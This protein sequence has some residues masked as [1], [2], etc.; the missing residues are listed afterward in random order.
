MFKF[1]PIVK[2]LV[3]GTETWLLSSVRGFESI[4]AD[5]PSKGKTLNEVYGGEFP[6]LV[7][8]IDANDDLSIQVHPNDDLARKRHNCNGKTE[9]WYVR[10]SESRAQLLSGLCRSLSKEE[11]SKLVEDG[12]I[13]GALSRYEVK[14]GDVFFLPAGR[15]HSI[16]GGCHI[17]EIQ[18]TSDITYRI[19]DYNRPG[20]DGKPREL[21]TELAKDAIDFSVQEDYRT[22]YHPEKNEE[23]DIV[24]CNHFISSVF[25]LDKAVSKDVSGISDS[26]VILC[27]EGSG[28]INGED[29]KEGDL[30]LAKGENNIKFIP[31]EDGLKLLTSYVPKG[32]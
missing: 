28:K 7:K 23:I 26:Y 32:K 12:T 29:I 6:L 4:V 15:I 13:T 9:M 8:F 30:F 16:G 22:P 27:L 18:Q 1:Q 21:H 14:E 10:K 3:W 25:D 2:H 20:M 5:G 11:Y 24:R 17:A 19:F 31:S